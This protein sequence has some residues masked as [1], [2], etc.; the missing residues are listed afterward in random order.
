MVKF[1]LAAIAVAGIGAGTGA[2][3][4]F[5]LPGG[6]AEVAVETTATSTAE[7]RATPTPDTPTPSLGGATPTITPLVTVAPG[8][9]YSDLNAGYAV[10]YPPDW[11]PAE[12]PFDPN[13]RDFVS[14]VE[15]VDV[16]GLRRG[17]VYVFGNPMR[18]SLEQWIA[19]HDPIFFDEPPVETTVAGLRALFSGVDSEGLPRALAY[20]DKTPLVLSIAGL[21][22]DDYARLAAGLRLVGE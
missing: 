14:A 11:K 21:K 17:S 18:R 6:E 15:F 9:E 5:A 8:P 2:G 13:I 10:V 16:D 1:V 12:V 4:Y 19:E 20:A 22:A 3:I 7:S